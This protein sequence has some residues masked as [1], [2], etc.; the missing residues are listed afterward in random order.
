MMDY[1]VGEQDSSELEYCLLNPNTRNIVQ[2]TVSDVV[3]TNK[4]FEDLYGKKVEPRVQYLLEHSE[5]AN[6]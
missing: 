6:G 5:E 1:H 3:K 2:L 4:L